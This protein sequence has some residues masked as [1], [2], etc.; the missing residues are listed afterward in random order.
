ME[1]GGVEWEP[2]NIWTLVCLPWTIHP[3]SSQSIF[4]VTRPLNSLF[5]DHLVLL[6]VY[7]YIIP[8]PS[9]LSSLSYGC[10]PWSVC[11]LYP[12]PKGGQL[13]L[14]VGDPRIILLSL[15]IIIFI[16]IPGGELASYLTW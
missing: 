8:R 2:P 16:I 4:T 3:L 5:P 7:L 11:L 9:P 14:M 12:H 1:G 6:S 13:S 10:T 15:I